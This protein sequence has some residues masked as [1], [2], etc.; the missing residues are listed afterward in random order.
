MRV[1]ILGMGAIGHVVARALE[2]RVDLVRV[3]R[4]RS[5][6]SA[7]ERPVDAAVVCVKTYGTGWAAETAARVLAP[8]GVVVTV[9][10]G[11]GNE[12]VLSARLGPDRISV[13]VIYVG[14][15]LLPDGSLFATGAGRVELGRPRSGTAVAGLE[16]L[17][18]T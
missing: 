11:L 3:D 12:E 4:T 6:L 5:P 15:R 7:S 1:A 9:Q 2:G 18:S 13:G 8:D 14:A 16:E 17:A 10:N